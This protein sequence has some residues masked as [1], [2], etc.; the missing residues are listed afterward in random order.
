MTKTCGSVVALICQ[1][2]ISNCK[3]LSTRA[4]TASVASARHR[5]VYLQYFAAILFFFILHLFSLS[6][7][8]TRE[9]TVAQ[10]L[11]LFLKQLSIEFNHLK[12]VSNHYD[13]RPKKSILRRASSSI[14]SVLPL[15]QNN[16]QHPFSASIPRQVL[17]THIDSFAFD[18]Q[19]PCRFVGQPVRH[20]LSTCEDRPASVQCLDDAKTSSKRKQFKRKRKRFRTSSFRKWT[21]LIF[22][23]ILSFLFLRKNGQTKNHKLR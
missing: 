18:P 11:F 3:N 13:H 15:N 8:A 2:N 6:T 17:F 10:F 12:I 21:G 16:S 22:N 1:S 4:D 9:E 5:E 7:M 23:W 19:M 14:N 20:E